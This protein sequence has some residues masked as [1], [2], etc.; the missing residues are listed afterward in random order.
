MW[1]PAAGINLGA[2]D[3]P[4]LGQDLDVVDLATVD[5]DGVRRQHLARLLLSRPRNGIVQADAAIAR[6]IA[7]RELQ[8]V[9]IKRSGRDR[10]NGQ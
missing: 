2:L 6:S 5:I 8:T 7:L 1:L 4:V 9:V 3:A 10:C